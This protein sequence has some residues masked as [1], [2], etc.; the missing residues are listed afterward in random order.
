MHKCIHTNIHTI[1]VTSAMK[2]ILYKLFPLV[3]KHARDDI[4]LADIPAPH[5]S[6]LLQIQVG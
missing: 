2:V 5:R 3:D 6:I 1:R 4:Q